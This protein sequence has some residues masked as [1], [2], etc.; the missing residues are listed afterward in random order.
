MTSGMTNAKNGAHRGISQEE[1]AGGEEPGAIVAEN[2]AARSGDEGS[3]VAMA[4]MIASLRAPL[5]TESASVLCT[6][7]TMSSFDAA[8]PE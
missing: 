4:S 6:L 5:A 8:L 1:A 2:S 3:S 7:L